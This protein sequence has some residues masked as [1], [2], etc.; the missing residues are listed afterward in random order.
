MEYLRVAKQIARQCLWLLLT[1]RTL[2]TSSFNMRFSLSVLHCAVFCHLSWHADCLPTD[3]QSLS[4]HLAAQNNGPSEV[5]R[6]DTRDPENIKQ[7]GGFL[8]WEPLKRTD[9][10]YSLQ[11]H[12]VGW[13][14]YFHEASL[15]EFDTRFVSTSEDIQSSATYATKNGY[16]YRIKTTP[17]AVDVNKSF[18]EKGRL[19][20]FPLEKEYAF[21]HG[22]SWSQVK[23]YRQIG[24]PWIENEDYDKN[25]DKFQS[26]GAQ[27]GL[28]E[29]DPGVVGRVAAK[30]MSSSANLEANALGAAPSFCAASRTSCIP[31]FAKTSK[32]FESKWG[33]V[34]SKALDG[35]PDPNFKKPSQQKPELLEHGIDESG[36]HHSAPTAQY[37]PGS[38]NEDDGPMPRPVH[39]SPGSKQP[40]NDG[41]PR[42]E[43]KPSKPFPD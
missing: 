37:Q 12:V 8:T 30:I 34:G 10:G 40:D 15:A 35:L 27:P 6:G 41:P 25:F 17:N 36:N 16:I 19:S 3:D 38:G 9:Q 22:I 13:G 33:A 11:N 18:S 20:P 28:L 42:L 1:S 39:E 29:P 23:A 43:R 14:S 24:G 7:A 31:K 5:Y 26:A 21:I 4:S 32:G 2:Y